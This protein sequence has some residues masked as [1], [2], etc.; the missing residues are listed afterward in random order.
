MHI[1]LRSRWVAPALLPLVAFL[2]PPLQEPGG[3][4]GSEAQE[5]TSTR[6]SSIPSPHLAGDEEVPLAG[7]A[8]LYVTVTGLGSAEGSIRI[9]L[10]DDPDDFTDS[11]SVAAVVPATDIAPGW[12]VRVPFGRYAVAVIHDEDDDGELDTNFLGMPQER[13]G[14]S[15][16]ARG[17]FGPP[18]FEDASVDVR[19]PTVRV[20]V[21]VR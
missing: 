2:S 7:E 5:A 19:G 17:T 20:P 9:A 12:S 15:N 4:I 18:S 8:E 21:R 10:F 16:D 1:R 3:G 14:F 6:E 13:Y 11:P